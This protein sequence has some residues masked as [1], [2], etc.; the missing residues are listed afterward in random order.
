MDELKSI[1][2][3]LQELWGFEQDANYHLLVG[4][5]YIPHCTCPLIDNK[6]LLGTSKRIYMSNCPIHNDLYVEHK[7]EHAY[8]NTVGN[9]IVCC[10]CG[11]VFMR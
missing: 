9:L 3:E 5:G 6:E 11:T 10:D 7:C 2:F 8:T 4:E 1:E